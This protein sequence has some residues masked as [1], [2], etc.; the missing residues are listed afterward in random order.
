MVEYEK[1]VARLKASNF[2]CEGVAGGTHWTGKRNQAQISNAR[3]VGICRLRR[4]KGENARL[5]NL[6][7]AREKVRAQSRYIT[8]AV[9]GDRQ[10]KT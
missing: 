3:T 7:K 6:A 2:I 9:S 1:T 5:K 8:D 4:S 10:P